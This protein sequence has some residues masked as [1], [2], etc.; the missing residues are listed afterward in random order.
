MRHFRPAL[1]LLTL[2]VMACQTEI[3][4]EA[5]TI[6]A[7]PAPN[8]SPVVEPGGANQTVGTEGGR[9]LE[10]V[11][12]ATTE[13][14]TVFY[15]FYPL[16]ETQATLKST[17]KM[18]GIVRV[19]EGSASGKTL[20]LRVKPDAEPFLYAFADPQPKVGSTYSVHAEITAGDN[21]YV[22][23]YTYLHRAK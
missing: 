14:G 22:A 8:A 4:P 17:T 5:P 2:A 3:Y 20:T 19:A 1:P 9:F 23:D 7:R 21:S 18:S 10:F 6:A 16:D 15:A 11:A 13:K 12:A